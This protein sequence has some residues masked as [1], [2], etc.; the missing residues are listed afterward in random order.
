[1]HFEFPI[2]SI[3]K[4]IDGDSVRVFVDL[5]FKLRIEADIRINGVDT[6]EVRGEQREYG[7]FV[8]EQVKQW[9]EARWLGGLT[10]LSYELDK[11]GRV[12]GDI[13][14]NTPD[15]ELLSVFLLE[16][17]LARPYSG[18]ARGPWTPDQLSTIIE[19]MG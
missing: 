19:R 10:L 16:N 11:Y 9:M 2:H 12:L 17:R 8:K 3:I 4:L 14:P 13:R 6:P 18:G 15:N 5:G 1:M 7:R